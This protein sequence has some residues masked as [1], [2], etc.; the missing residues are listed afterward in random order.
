MGPKGSYTEQVDNRRGLEGCRVLVTGA[1][2]FIGGAL[3]ARLLAAGSEVHGVSRSGGANAAVQWHPG[4]LTQSGSAGELLGA[5]RPDIV[6]HLASLVTGSRSLDSVEPL[7]HANLS[8]TVR[9]LTAAAR[10]GVGQVVLAGSMEEP[11]G[12]DDP[13]PCSPYAAAKWA[14]TGYGRMFHA[15]YGLS[16]VTARIFMTYGPGQRDLTKLVPYTILSLLR[17]EA[18]EY[19]SG[20]R[21]VDWVYVDDVAEALLVLGR[22]ASGVYDVGTGVKTSVRCVVEEIAAWMDAPV[23][24]R[25]G[26]LPDRALEVTRSADV[27]PTRQATG[28]SAKVSLRE[29]LKKTVEWYTE[30]YPNGRA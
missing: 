13:V 30:H 22:T 19:S 27:E 12:E 28:W 14:S 10:A 20:A 18:P 9:L 3:C 21:E 1:S 11:Y 8:S 24:P 4:D 29:G 15:L 7:F 23:G 25:F 5:V 16:V 17:G 2:G 6:F 26:A